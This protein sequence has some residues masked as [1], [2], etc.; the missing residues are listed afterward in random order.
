M[1]AGKLEFFAHT[2]QLWGVDGFGLASS[3]V[4]VT[5]PGGVAR[6]GVRTVELD[7]NYAQPQRELLRIYIQKSTY[8]ETIAEGNK[9]LLV[10]PEDKTAL[11]YLGYAY[12]K[13]GRRVEA[14]KV[15]D[16]LNA[17]SEHKYVPATSRAGIYAG[18]G[19]N[20]KAFEWLEK[21]YEDRALGAGFGTIKGDPVFDPLPSDPRFA[22]LL[23]RMNLQ[24]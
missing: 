11:Y 22:G 6:S 14:Q 15:L 5:K 23:R 13:A 20:D 24:P 1:A 19:E 3:R 18:L 16:Q 2:Q 12:A 10:A 8:K 21:A 17:L 4:N 9:R 7:P